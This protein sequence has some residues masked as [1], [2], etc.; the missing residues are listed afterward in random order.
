MYTKLKKNGKMNIIDEIKEFAAQAADK[1]LRE[2]RKAYELKSEDEFKQILR[3]QGLTMPVIRRQIERQVMAEQ[4]VTSLL[5]EKGHRV[6][7]S[8]MRE[9]YDAH[10]DEFKAPDRVKWQHLFVSRA[11]HGSAQAARDRA[12]EVRRKAVRGD[13]FAALVKQHDDGFAA[14]QN[15]FGTGEKR[16][17]I[18]PIDLEQVVWSLKP[19]QMS[20]VIET[21][22]GYH[23]VKVVER[24]YAG[25][26]PF[27]SKV[28]GQI[29]DKLN[30][31]L[32]EAEYKKLVEEL[33]RKGVVRV[34]ETE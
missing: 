26:R 14:K 11:R 5:K 31:K 6:G 15:G 17:E 18:Q 32:R 25:L 30:R 9:Y 7:L 27:D 12:E 23:V 2:I 3:L 34:F 33:W 10:P 13:D 24:D 20:E 19:G 1:Q 28:Q 16:G 21:P 4:Y 8:E 22:T 29:R